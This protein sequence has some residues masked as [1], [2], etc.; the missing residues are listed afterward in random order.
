MS[1]L[2]HTASDNSDSSS[3]SDEGDDKESQRRREERRERRRLREEK[4]TK[5]RERE[6]IR[7][8]RKRRIGEGGLTLPKAS[9]MGLCSSKNGEESGVFVRRDLEDESG[10]VDISMADLEATSST[11]APNGPP[12]TTTSRRINRTG[13]APVKE[14]ASAT[15]MPKAKTKSTATSTSR[16]QRTKRRPPSPP[17]PPEPRSAKRARVQSDGASTSANPTSLPTPTSMLEDSDA[18]GEQDGD[19]TGEKVELTKNGKPRNETYKQAWS[20]EEQHELERLLQEIPD[21]EKNRCVSTPLLML[22]RSLYIANAAPFVV[23]IGGP[24]SRKP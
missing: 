21:G 22:A 24:R 2:Q 10:E 20:V 19:G 9:R 14:E 6:K 15:V 11:P 16:S 4:K 18:D 1:A 7:E 3:S 23:H 12:S 5:E 13:T 8:L 17:P